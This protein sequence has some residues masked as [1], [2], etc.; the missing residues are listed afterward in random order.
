MDKKDYEALKTKVKKEQEEKKEILK[1][2]KDKEDMDTNTASMVL[3]SLL[4]TEV[5]SKTTKAT[6]AVNNKALTIKE[7]NADDAANKDK[8]KTE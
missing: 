7:V 2:I 5:R 4:S 8:T 3:K 1:S 6:S